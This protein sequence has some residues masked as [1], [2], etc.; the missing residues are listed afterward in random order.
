VASKS[1]PSSMIAVPSTHFGSL[2]RSRR[3]RLRLPTPI[4]PHHRFGLQPI[5]VAAGVLCHG[6][7]GVALLGGAIPV[8]VIVSCRLQVHGILG[9]MPDA[10]KVC[11]HDCP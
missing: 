9:F 7:L 5:S 2:A 4:Y 11:F 8:S 10:A 6:P 3:E 1:R